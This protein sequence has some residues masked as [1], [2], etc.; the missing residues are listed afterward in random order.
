MLGL[1]SFMASEVDRN[2]WKLLP[3]ERVFWGG[4]PTPGVARE[5]YWAIGAG[6][7]IALASVSACFACL[8]AIADM[9][10]AQQTLFIAAYLALFGIGVAL[11]PRYL[12]DRCEYVVT[13]RRVLWRR[14][15]YRRSMDLRGITFARVRWHPSAPGVG[16]LECVR[17]VPFGPFARKQRLVLHDIR[18]PDAL[19]AMIRGQERAPN[20]GDAEIPMIERLDADEHVVWGGHPEGTLLGHREVATAIGGVLV[21]GLGIRYGMEAGGIL[22]GLEDVGLPVMST[23]WL[24]LFLAVL[25]SWVVITSIGCGLVWYGLFRAR[26][27]GRDTEY[28]LTSKRLLIRRGRTELSVDRH[29]IVDVADAPGWRGVRHLF[30]VLDAP[31]S[32]ALADSGALQT[33]PPPRDSVPPVLYDLRD[34][35]PLKRLILE[36][37]SRP[38]LP[39]V[40]DAA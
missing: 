21:V 31:Q 17:A 14:G 30:L 9:P 40:R 12:R 23:P 32:R 27:L 16:S 29:R 4:G 2:S 38:S 15:N 22:L 7:L 6:V 20:Q 8:L 25:I 3:N 5:R 24:L 13:D 37:D 33:L 28:V 36:R 10:G 1:H 34:V 19:L 26:A 39:P 11:A 35:E 18:E